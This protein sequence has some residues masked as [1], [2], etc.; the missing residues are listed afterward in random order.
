MQLNVNFKLHFPTVTSHNGL[1][2]SAYSA[3]QECATKVGKRVF[4][5]K[6]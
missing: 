1:N 2:T 3:S 4:L 5:H 6:N